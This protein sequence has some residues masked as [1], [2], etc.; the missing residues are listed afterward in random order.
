[1]KKRRRILA[2]ILALTMILSSL[3][4]TTA[5]ADTCG[6]LE[7]ED[8]YQ[9]SEEEVVK[10]PILHWAIRAAMNSIQGGVKLTADIV[11]D[12]SVKD[13]SYELCAHPEDFQTEEW[14]GKQYWIEDLEGLQYATSARMIDIAYT[15]AVTGKS[16]SDLTPIS[17]LTQLETLILKQNGITGIDALSKL[18]NLKTLDVAS[19]ELD[20]IS[21]VADMAKLES[22][23]VFSNKITSVDALSNLENLE[24]ITMAYN[25]I[26]KLPDLSKLT[27]VKFLDVSHN[28]L[29]DVSEIAKMKNLEQLNLSGNSGITDITPLAGL[30]K[31]EKANTA[32][33][34]NSKKDDLF[35]AIEVNKLFNLFNISKM[36]EAD[37]TNV[38]NA[39]DAY[40][41]LTDEQKTYFE[42]ARIEAARSNMEKVQ[43]GGAAQYYPEYD[44]EGEKQPVFD[45]ITISVVNKSGNPMAGVSFEKV[46]SIQGE[47]SVL[48]T[49]VTDSVGEFTLKHNPQDALYDEIIVRPAGDDYVAEPEYI[50]YSTSW[51]N[52]TATVN[53]AA[54][55][56]L[57][58]IQ[59][60]LTLKE[61]YVDITELKA[62][63]TQAGEVEEAYK[64][65]NDSYQ[66][67]EEA[68]ANAKAAL[69]D[70]N[71][72]K[73]TVDNAAAGL[74][75]AIANL[76]KATILTELKLIVKDEN[77]NVF[78]RP[79]K[80]QI[81]VPETGAE[82]WN[83]LSDPYTG[84]AY[85]K[86]APGWAD[87][88]VWEIVACYEEPYEIT[89]ITVTV[90][91]ENGQRY[92]KT[93][94]GKSVDID[95]EKVVV[96]TPREGGA[97]DQN[98]ER[99]P[100]SAV[101]QEVLAKAKEIKTADYTPAS[102]EILEKAIAD[103]QSAIEAADASQEDYNAA[104]AAL[105]TAES[106]LVK[107]ADKAALQNE[108][109]LKNSY[110]ESLYTKNTWAEYKNK[111]EAAETVYA[112]GNATQKEVDDAVQAL[113][114]ASTGLV[115]KAD[116]SGLEAKLAEAEALKAED[117]VSGYD[118]LQ[119]AIAEAQEVL[120]KEEPTKAELDAQ[121]EALQEAID[122]L[123]KKPVEPD[124]S[125]TSS[126]FRAKVVDE[127]GDP[128]EGVKFEAVIGT[129]VDKAVPMTS[130][131]N[132][133]IT[134]Y[135]YGPLQYGK[136][137]YIRL[138]DD[139][140][141]TEDEHYFTVNSSSYVA[142]IATV[143]GQPFEEGVKLTY[144][145]KEATGGETPEPAEKVLC[146]TYTFR[147]KVVDKDGKAMEGVQFNLVPDYSGVT[148]KTIT[149]DADGIME[150][151][152]DVADDFALSY[153]VELVGEDFIVEKPIGIFTF[154]TDYESKISHVN[155]VALAEADEV[156]FE[157]AEAGSEAP[158]PEPTDTVL[159][160]ASTF[161]AKV[162]DKDGK[163]VNGVVFTLSDGTE[164]VSKDGKIERAVGFYEVY[165]EYTVTL[166]D[167]QGWTCGTTVTCYQG[168][169]YTTGA[170]LEE[171][172]GKTLAEAGEIV[173]E[174]VK[175]GGETPDPEPTDA[176]LSDAST[177]RAKVVDKDGKAVDGV[178]FTLS[179]GTE[180]VSKDGKIERAVGFYEV[181]KEY[182]VTLKEGQGWTC[183][184]TVTC[185]Q[186]GSYTTG[187]KL[188]EI[189]GKALAEA[190][191]IV[192]EL[193]KTGGE[194]P[195]PEP[196]DKVLCETYTFR[197]KVVD[198]DGK[199]MEGVQFNLV[200]NYPEVTTKTITTDANGIMVYEIN[201]SD[202]FSLSYTVELVGE[203]YVIS[204]PFGIF[205]FKTDYASKITHVNGVALAEAGEVVFVLAKAGGDTP[206]VADKKEL[207]EQID[208][209][210]PFEGKAEDY[211]FDSY[212][213]FIDALNDAK[214]V[215]ADENATQ[216]QVD[217]A[218]ETLKITRLA[219]IP[220]E[221][222]AVT[223]KY[224]IRVQVV[225]GAGNKVTDAIPFKVGN[226]TQN[227]KNGVIE[228]WVSGGDSGVTSMVI[229]LKDGE[230]VLEGKTYVT[231]PK[232]HV[233]TLA[234]YAGDV[235]V[236][237]IDGEPLEGTKE[238]KFTL[239]EKAVEVVD[240]TVLAEKIAEMDEIKQGNYTKNSYNALKDAI[241]AAKAVND[242]EAATK[243]AVD[244]AVKALDD[245]KAALK[246]V[247]GIRTLVI[248][249]TDKDGNAAPAN[250][251]FERYDVKY[252]AVNSMFANDGKLE[253]KLGEYEGG[254]YEIYLPEDSA[255]IATPGLI[256]VHVGTEDGTPVIETINGKP[257]A[258]SDLQIVLTEKGIDTSDIL[259]FRAKVVDEDGNALEGI[260]FEVKNG[261]PDLIES[262]ENGIIEY[263]V[264]AWDTDMTMTVSLKDNKKWTCDKEVAF[265]VIVDP[266]DP[267]RGI[268]DKIDG[269][270]V[271]D[272]GQIVFELQKPALAF[273]GASL[274]L[275]NDLTIN[276]R[277]KAK[278][279]TEI[280]YAEPYVIFSM[281]GVESKVTE[282]IV[283]NDE[284]VFNFDNIA[285]H[286]MGD[287][288]LAT[289]YADYEGIEYKSKTV[290]YSVE[291]YTYNMLGKYTA[292]G[293]AKFRTLL[294]DL[295]VYGEKSQIFKA[296]KTD[297][298]VSAKLT[299]EQR[300]FG[301]KENRELVSVQN[302]EYETIENP[303][304]IWNGAGLNLNESV[305]IRFSI[306]AEENAD[307][308]L[309]IKGESGEEW[310]VPAS[311]F[312][313]TSDGYNVYFEGL[314]AGQMSE[315][316][317]ATF[318]E[319]ET[320]VSNTACYSIESYAY[321][322]QNS[323]DTNLAELVK[324][325]MRY[326]DAAY[327]FAK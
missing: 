59:F 135:T 286:Q 39:L 187:A 282:Y 314:N 5:Y 206:S 83:V 116:K 269:K 265:S 268:I 299:D 172:N 22:L 32:L 133:I 76:E 166:K 235:Y 110:T 313:K 249:V 308:T 160:D 147:A 70:V 136:T 134:Y 117:Y 52:T 142:T 266:A 2:F 47:E 107:A 230:V 291:Q 12:K 84:A 294:V 48:K 208:F 6:G 65:T 26:T 35:A 128:V 290:D 162:V 144:T 196:S 97:E 181:Y 324:A 198:K 73:E 16:I 24:Y 63:I 296:Y 173:F 66:N 310:T 58:E 163:A 245:A 50:T 88:K 301:T 61:E 259:T 139:R 7:P 8:V 189:N 305:I 40:D 264:T 20:D 72:S 27:K 183:G 284:Y 319:G 25:K 289:L 30:L 240:K 157:L 54:A 28:Q 3:S 19:N 179:D 4:G 80:F 221:K 90:G 251:K 17:G 224:I 204:E 10:D 141:T 222:P 311:E 171:I 92:Y 241:D 23:N 42:D 41:A 327:I 9:P 225:D 129:E 306:K 309:K 56:G 67:F 255:Y 195:D 108:I 323:T 46:V 209:S 178:T 18:V 174:L 161:R 219:L 91:V 192:F 140:Y 212:K 177:F 89:P 292:P 315:S 126:M 227:S 78:S 165:K 182:T 217:Q 15:S 101:L 215:A 155:G 233:F 114:K 201:K 169:S 193:V 143:N 260:E 153:R 236:S 273:S 237:E 205:T 132:G 218:A 95:F 57:E 164:L 325:M 272:A 253:W 256:K 96:V 298:L 270:S 29:T 146:D 98:N 307:L 86:A 262:D 304:V 242:D 200:P 122:A 159:S 180:L 194:T 184:T 232:Q 317:Y 316:V 278:L 62:A 36:K 300:A 248:P 44:V 280:G 79:F 297:E 320:A 113:K 271:E 175:A 276:Y 94:D 213:A 156:V 55:T 106:G 149:T 252:W 130:N 243:E 11:A 14:E 199:A 288:I 87:G 246:E 82:A 34:D 207:N 158:D 258:E 111:L 13:I 263:A 238:V 51:S 131:K 214:L 285:P 120:D 64:Y 81:K 279:F 247:T 60:I 250:V 223:E 321:K 68:L 74:K 152:I 100:D 102:V 191:E 188:E 295:L 322:Q 257:A 234:E 228:Y 145:V 277:A 186:G 281:N 274:T 93:V 239:V 138:A 197:A 21:A 85:L 216:K 104:I 220:V 303:S 105:E 103:A 318:Y 31:L 119:A 71:A 231:E 254:D 275:Y 229:E 33:P 170:K 267:N 124:Y 261:D 210:A 45:S 37:I 99:K 53:G 125:C 38:K 211:T 109:S 176:V 77:G 203:D 167:G 154:R 312:E 185:Y 283:E 202:D 226:S 168:G 43:N 127:N 287:T 123:E 118:A 49:V 302:A 151:E 190:G 121:I 75:E 326:G 150:Y 112:D 137:T 115:L 1:M 69:D 244:A 293:Y 148:T